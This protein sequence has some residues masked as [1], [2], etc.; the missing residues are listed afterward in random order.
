MEAGCSVGCVADGLRNHSDSEG[1]IRSGMV[2][3]VSG[4]SCVSH[5]WCDWVRVSSCCEK[6]ILLVASG[7]A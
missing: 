5:S 4:R 7:A 6:G 1:V 2:F 3:G